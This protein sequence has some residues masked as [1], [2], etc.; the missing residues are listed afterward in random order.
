M[1]L[2]PSG[3]LYTATLPQGPGTAQWR[4]SV[5]MFLWRTLLGP[6]RPLPWHPDCAT[7]PRPATVG[8]RCRAAQP[9]SPPHA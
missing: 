6:T 1:S 3:D 7:R 5:Q 8:G 4:V 9:R 2:A